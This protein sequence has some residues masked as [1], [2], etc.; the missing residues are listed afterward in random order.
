MRVLRPLRPYGSVTIA[1]CLTLIAVTV[2][3]PTRAESDEDWR[4][5]HE[6][7]ASGRILP[8]PQILERLQADYRGEVLEVELEREDGAIVYEIKMIGAEGQIVEFEVDATTGRIIG[9]EG[10]NIDGMKRQ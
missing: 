6:E 8:L 7:V 1:V 4:N 2:S 10:V 5:L 3:Q 9:I